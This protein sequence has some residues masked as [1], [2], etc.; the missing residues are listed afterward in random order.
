VHYYRDVQGWQLAHTVDRRGVTA[1]LLTRRARLQ[2][3]L[4]D[5]IVAAP[6][7]AEHA[8][9][10]GGLPPASAQNPETDST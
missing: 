2:P 10:P 9:M 3:D 7:P 6:P 1:Y 5:R 4:A 8:A